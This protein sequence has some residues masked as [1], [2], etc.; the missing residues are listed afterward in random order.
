MDDEPYTGDLDLGSVSTWDELVALLRKV[1]VRADKP[2]LRTLEARARHGA[3]PLSKTGA[4][5][6][7]KGVRFPRKGA[8]VGFLRACGVPDDGIEP[9]RRAWERIAA[10]EGPTWP[11]VLEATP[12]PQGQASA[13][14]QHPHPMDSAA[15][16]GSQARRIDADHSPSGSTSSAESSEV[17]HLREQV[18]RLTRANEQLRSL[19]AVRQRSATDE[20]GSD[21]ADSGEETHRTLV[22]QSMWHFPDGSPITLVGHR[23]PPAYRPPSADPKNPNYVRFTELADLDTL[24]DVHGVIR[25]CNPGSQVVITAAQDLSQR[26]VAN[27]LVLIGGWTWE[28]VE[29]WFSRVFA[30][31]IELGDPFERGAIVVRLPEGGKRE[32][33]YTVVDEGV[34]EDIGFF[35]CGKN[36]SA[37]RRKLI[38]CGGIT[39]RGVHGAALCFIDPEMRERNEEYLMS[40]FSNEATCCIVMR[41]PIINN[42]PLTPD[43][44]KG[45]SRLFEWCDA[46]AGAG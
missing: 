16:E 19:L 34:I 29:P 26:S 17:N 33:K 6:I 20:L 4:A 15:H 46:N 43:L 7:L 10:G 42:D 28:A 27:H 45:E 44:T 40:H 38:V 14:A 3:T 35:A 32:F 39:T 25:A 21:R 36:P 22:H 31:P 5:E 8:I 11:E 18:S 9:W 12:R 41:V 30:I 23:L 37:P 13:A 2:S 24:I 1:Y